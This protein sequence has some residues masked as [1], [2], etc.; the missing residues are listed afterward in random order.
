MKL[1]WVKA[2]LDQTA[3][4]AKHGASEL[5]RW[6][7]NVAADELAGQRADRAVTSDAVAQVRRAD[8]LMSTFSQY[9]SQKAEILLTTQNK[10]DLLRKSEAK[11]KAFNKRR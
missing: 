1:A 11:P 9:L 5:G 7:L 3:F 2:H 8:H 6:R 4:E 10:K